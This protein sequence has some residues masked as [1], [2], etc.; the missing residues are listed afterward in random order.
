VF[1]LSP[2]WLQSRGLSALL[3]DLDNTLIPYGDQGEPSKALLDWL[4]AVKGA[5][6]QTFLVSNA[7]PGRVRY[8]GERLGLPGLGLAAK[9]WLGFRRAIRRWKLRP[10]QVAVV[11]DQL[12]TDVL[13]GNLVGAHTVLVAPLSKQELGYTRL[14]RRLERWVLNR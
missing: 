5:G 12:F 2:E 6:V 3:L 4:A 9:P 11:G 8:W 10:E 14:V 7:K 13:G 1:Q